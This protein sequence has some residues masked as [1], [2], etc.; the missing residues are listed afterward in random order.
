MHIEVLNEAVRN[1]P[2]E[3]M[4]IHLCWGNYE[5]PHNH[6]IPLRD[7]IEPVLKAKP[8]GLSFEGANPRHA[9]EWKLFREIRLP[10]AKS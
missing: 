4:R 3:R 5:G 10:P 9:H 8:A 1:I 2:A 6:D 7:I